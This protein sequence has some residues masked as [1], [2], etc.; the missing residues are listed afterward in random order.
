LNRT[1]HENL[2][3]RLLLIGLLLIGLVLVHAVRPAGTLAEQ[4]SDAGAGQARQLQADVEF[5]ASEDLRGR[6][7][8]DE[9]ID[10]AA[11]FVAGRMS[12]IGLDTEAVDGSPFQPLKIR[13]DA[14]A[15][16]VENNR[17]EISH[18]GGEFDPLAASLSKGM[19]PLAIGSEVGQVSGRLVFVGYGI[20]APKLDYDDYQGIDVSGATVILLRKEPGMN[21]PASKFSGTRTTSH[22]F[23]STKI[24]NAISHGA[25]AVIIVNDPLSV[26]QSVQDARQRIDQETRRI[27]R[28]RRQIDELP[29]RAVNSRQTLSQKI[30]SIES[31]VASMRQNLELVKQG[32]LRI[33]EAGGPDAGEDSI[34]VV[35]LARDLA[36][37]VLTQSLGRSLK[38]IEEQIDQTYSPQSAALPD[39]T[40]NLRVELKP[41]LAET[42]NVIGVLAGRGALA[43][44]TVV[45]GAHYDH[46]GMGGFGS[47]APGTIAVHNGADDN[48]SGTACL[49]SSAA[50]LRRR[51]AQR[52]AH[53]R[54]VFIAFTGEERGLHGSKHYVRSPVFPLESTVAMVNLDM[55]GRLRDNE[56]I[57]YGTGSGDLL[58]GILESANEVQQFNL[59][60][61]ASGWGPS[62]HQSFYEV[63]LPVLFFFTGIHN[64]YHRPTD[65]SDK[66]DFGGLSRITDIVSEV[67]FALATGEQRPNY[68]ETENRVRIRRQLTAFM[69][70]SLSDRG[71]HVVLSGT[72]AGG[73]AERGGLRTGDRLE[74]LGNQRVRTA[75]DVLE[76]L[77]RR[78]PGDQLK[79]QVTRDTKTIDVTIK[80]AARPAG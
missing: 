35:S 57:V 55:V 56:L 34:P 64:D 62:D 7:V 21:D 27:Q 12:E 33:S 31:M 11:R 44:E 41:T 77:R 53:R 49:L 40:V 70:V 20:T 51:L 46:V 14:Q 3:A 32:V 10:Q 17:I 58:D 18:S 15:G 37:T 67:T 28:I 29:A 38:Q 74:K 23:F 50:K 45:L 75:S 59:F 16:A 5:L 71:D 78:S 24:D 66:I 13:L 68:T 6:G 52:S 69:G 9:T 25:S 72:T 76:L 19:N 47:L 73:P 26:L 80:L 65:D 60:K 4:P 22:A 30:Q 54:I 43:D 79:V 48:A 61:V 1:N 36:D 8:D 2:I 42:S 63:G 39:R